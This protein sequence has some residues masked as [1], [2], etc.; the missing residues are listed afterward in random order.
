MTGGALS[1][2]GIVR[3]PKMAQPHGLL[4]CYLIKKKCVVILKTTTYSCCSKC[5]INMSLIHMNDWCQ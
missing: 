2:R 1:G 5:F 3:I 4:L